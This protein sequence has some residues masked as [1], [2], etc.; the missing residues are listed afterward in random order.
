MRRTQDGAGIEDKG[1][2]KSRRLDRDRCI[3][4]L[5]QELLLETFSLLPFT[6][7]LTCRG[8]SRLWKQVASDDS[9]WRG[10][11]EEN[12]GRLSS[13]PR[14]ELDCYWLD[15]FRQRYNW[16]LGKCSI[17]SIQLGT[18]EKQRLTACAG[19]RFTFS[20][21]A[22]HQELTVL[23][24]GTSKLLTQT[25]LED[26]VS[27]ERWKY[28]ENSITEFSA[29]WED[30]N[31]QIAVGNQFGDALILEYNVVVM[32]FVVRA[33]LPMGL[34]TGVFPVRKISCRFP[35]VAALHSDFVL[36]IYSITT[37]RR[38]QRVYQ[39]RAGYFTRDDFALAIDRSSV[40][41]SNRAS[42]CVSIAHNQKLLVNSWAVCLQEFHFDSSCNLQVTRM[43]KMKPK[44]PSSSATPTCI[45]YKYPYLLTGHD[46]NNLSLYSVSSTASHL[47]IK[48]G[49]PLPGHTSGVQHINVGKHG[50]AIS[51]AHGY[52][53]LRWDLD[54]A[55]ESR[56]PVAGTL[57]NGTPR[58]FV[59]ESSRNCSGDFFHFDEDSSLLVVDLVDQRAEKKLI[60]YDFTVN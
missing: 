35:I 25:K 58:H 46:N 53:F 52:N 16:H 24:I 34:K 30:E 7:L 44:E 23:D 49:E 6:D 48:L 15:R 13:V 12:F 43:A 3:G 57:L 47:R 56:K 9:L 38:P 21:S 59:G 17:R 41:D 8:V 29:H 1:V 22:R 55:L 31:P 54:D 28:D 36:T 60:I 50:R 32:E 4:S 20:L 11:Y 33:W 18:H 2:L 37:K 40:L 42:F 26:M 45:T 5:S 19:G 27:C 39:A 14:K 10:H 51:M